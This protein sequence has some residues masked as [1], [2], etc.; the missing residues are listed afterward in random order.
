M[1]CSIIAYGIEQID[2]DKFADMLVTGGYFVVGKDR[3]KTLETY[4]VEL[5]VTNTE[6]QVR[7]KR[8]KTIVSQNLW[9]FGGGD[10]TILIEG[11]F[12][13]RHNHV[14]MKIPG[15]DRAMLPELPKIVKFFTDAGKKVHCEHTGDELEY[16][17]PV[18]KVCATV[19]RME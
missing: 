9:I 11:M 6:E 1:V 2:W 12:E 7:R 3:G 15:D 16:V 4:F 18:K 5:Q 10:Y 13:T 17:Y 19:T 8:G 14:S